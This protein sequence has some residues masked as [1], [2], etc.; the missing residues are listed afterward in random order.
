MI[1]QGKEVEIFGKKT[2]WGRRSSVT[3]PLKTAP[4]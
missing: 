1:Y 2:I 3:S 4:I